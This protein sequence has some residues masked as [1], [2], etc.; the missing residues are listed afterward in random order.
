MLQL[1]I[2]VLLRNVN[3]CDKVQR[4]VREIF[5]S[6]HGDLLKCKFYK[7]RT[8]CRASVK[9]TNSV[10]YILKLLRYAKNQDQRRLTNYNYRLCMPI[11]SQRDVQFGE[12]RLA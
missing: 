12:K 9:P 4:G 6:F 3:I 8:G 1:G 10:N 11:I 2:T 7:C 5:F